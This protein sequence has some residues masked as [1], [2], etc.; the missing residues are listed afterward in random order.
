MKDFFI[1][2]NISDTPWAEWIAWILEEAGYSIVIQSWDFRPGQNFVL[3][4]HRAVDETSKTLLV[5]SDDYLKAEFT[6]SEWAAVFIRDPQGQQQKLIPIRVAE[7]QPTGLLKAIVYVDLVGLPKADAHSALLG[8]FNERGKPSQAPPFPSQPEGTRERVTPEPKAFPGK[9]HQTSVT[10]SIEF[11][12]QASAEVVR[13]STLPE[14]RLALVKKLNSSPSQQ[15]NMLVFTLNPHPGL[16][17]A[18]P[19]PQ[20]DRSNALLTWAD[21][22][23]GCG[24]EVVSSVFE[25][26]VNPQDEA[27]AGKIQ[28]FDVVRPE[29]QPPC[30]RPI[31]RDLERSISFGE[32]KDSLLAHLVLA[33]LQKETNLELESDYDLSWITTGIRLSDESFVLIRQS[34][35]DRDWQ[36]DYSKTA[37]PILVGVARSFQRSSD[38]QAIIMR[39]CNV[40]AERLRL[41]LIW[42]E[43]PD[44]LNDLKNAIYRACL[45]AT[46][47][48]SDNVLVQIQYLTVIGPE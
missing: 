39:L 7:C 43:D 6:Q 23:G 18:M 22:E 47:V 33:E 19:A 16:I 26:I 38:A 4:M 9:A 30:H 17:P 35:C 20:G 13:K 27:V 24:L 29:D 37:T 46:E 14:E 2:Y 44:E 45:D 1:S 15:F 32:L 11:N 12:Q 5:L 28:P 40:M 48:E 31:L 8:A 41:K 42:P 25:Q 3:E 10:Q 34:A 21:G 36:R